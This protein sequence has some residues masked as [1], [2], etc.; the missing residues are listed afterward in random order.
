MIGSNPHVRKGL[1][2][3]SLIMVVSYFALGLL[4][5]LTPIF[6]E[7]V[8]NNRTIIGVIILLYGCFRL[9]MLMRYKKSSK[10]FQQN[11]E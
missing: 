3:F 8:P 1:Y 4:F 11:N 10:Y 6:S 9:Y 5:I 2:Y 7:V